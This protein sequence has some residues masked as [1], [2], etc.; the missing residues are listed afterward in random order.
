VTDDGYR[1][2]LMNP[3]DP[4]DL[5]S[6]SA[7]LRT[8]FPKAQQLTPRYLAWQ[9]RDNP[10][11]EAVGCNAW[12]GGEL[13]GHMAAYAMRGLLQGEEKKGQFMLNG[14]VAAG[15]RGKRLQSRISAAIFAESVRRG[16][17]FCFGT[18][19]RWST[20]P[21]L[22]R[23]RMVRPLEA[24][25]GFGVP[26]VKRAAPEPSFARL[27]SE[28]ALAWRLANPERAYAVRPAPGGAVILAATGTPGIAA[29]LDRCGPARLEPGGSVPGPL[30]LWLGLDPAVAWER[31]AF[32]PIPSALRP[33]PLNLVF[34][35]LTG[36]GL[37]PDPG[38]VRFHALDFDPY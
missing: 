6:V 30:R 33:S 23:F 27:W 25:I 22:T 24:R 12:L 38:R 10:D 11:G 8:V 20:G 16:F 5:E 17:V 3:H 32:L 2:A 28:E 36:G 15:H 26:S 9:Y 1:F 31:S 14:A 7:L 35:D 13:V 34:R 29:I 18:G 19:N 4:R 37:L 21:L